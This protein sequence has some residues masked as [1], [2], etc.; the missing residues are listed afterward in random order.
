MKKLMEL[1]LRRLKDVQS[2]SNAVETKR[3][4]N[5]VKLLSFGKVQS[6]LYLKVFSKTLLSCFIKTHFSLKDND[7][8]FP[9][10]IDVSLSAGLWCLKSQSRGTGICQ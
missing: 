7:R 4:G 2:V 5:M 9:S 1:S 8:K 3:N 10:N 6:A